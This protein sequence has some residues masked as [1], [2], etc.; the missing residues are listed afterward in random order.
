MIPEEA[1]IVAHM[2]LNILCSK[3]EILPFS[4]LK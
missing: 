3:T 4:S 2:S 1:S